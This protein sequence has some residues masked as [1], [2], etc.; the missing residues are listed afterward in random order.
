MA[1]SLIILLGPH[2]IGKMTVGQE[3][4]KMTGM[5]LFHNHMSIELALKL[6]DFGT[7]EWQY[8]SLGTAGQAYFALRLA[9]ANLIGQESSPLPI[10]LDDS[11]SEYDD[12]RALV[13]IKFLK[14]QSENSQIILFTCHSG[15]AD[16]AKN[17]DSDI[18]YL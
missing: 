13:A 10:L 18:K 11:F 14:E 17:L 1:K 8:L 2:A 3:L 15:I 5:R 6:F 4:A 16:M 9:L 7:K 12:T